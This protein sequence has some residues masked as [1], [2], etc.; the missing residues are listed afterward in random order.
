MRAAPRPAV[1]GCDR[2]QHYVDIPRCVFSCLDRFSGERD[3]RLRPDSS[4]P[5]SD[6]VLAVETICV[7]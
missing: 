2:R 7:T 1:G 5:L 3:L 4:H 6:V